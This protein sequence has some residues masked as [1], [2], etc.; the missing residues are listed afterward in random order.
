ML[1]AAL[2]TS[3]IGQQGMWLTDLYTGA[4]TFDNIRVYDVCF[5]LAVFPRRE[6]PR[7]GERT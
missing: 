4:S 5:L 6:M 7:G 1:F 2:E 3:N